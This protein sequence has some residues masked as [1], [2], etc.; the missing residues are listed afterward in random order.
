MWERRPQGKRGVA[1]W[2]PVSLR[3]KTQTPAGGGSECVS[4][5]LGNTD[6]VESLTQDKSPCGRHEDVQTNF[7]WKNEFAQSEIN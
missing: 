4:W 6:L 1:A 3:K 7:P 2:Q 5:H